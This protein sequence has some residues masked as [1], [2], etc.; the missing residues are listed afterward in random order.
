LSFRVSKAIQWGTLAAEVM[1]GKLVEA[2]SPG[3]HDGLDESTLNAALA[4]VTSMRP[5]LAMSLAT[6]HGVDVAPTCGKLLTTPREPSSSHENPFPKVEKRYIV[7]YI[8]MF[9][10]Q[11]GRAGTMTILFA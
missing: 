11:R 4:L 6:E 7:T 5:T 3:R 10:D 2:L 8:T 9:S 1:L